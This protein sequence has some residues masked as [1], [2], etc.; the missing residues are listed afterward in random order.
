MLD[1]GLIILSREKQPPV[2][3]VARHPDGLQHRGQIYAA[4]DV[5]VVRRCAVVLA[6]G[7]DALAPEASEPFVVFPFQREPFQLLFAYDK[8][9]ARIGADRA[10]ALKSRFAAEGQPHGLKQ[11]AVH[12]SFN[13]FS[14]Q[15][16]ISLRL[17][18]RESF[19]IC[20]PIPSTSSG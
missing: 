20:L 6:R 7:I 18:L 8:Q 15:K 9:P 3:L 5:A 13:P 17:N 19:F 12:H 16:S 4:S 14:E 1:D 11:A 2:G 10:L